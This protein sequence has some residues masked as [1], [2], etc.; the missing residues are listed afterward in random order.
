MVV[1]TSSLRYD[2]G[3]LLKGIGTRASKSRLT[4]YEARTLLEC[5]STCAKGRQEGV[6]CFL[7]KEGGKK[8]YMTLL[9]SVLSDGW[10]GKRVE[11]MR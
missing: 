1:A 10:I 9:D 4:T 5:L 6:S 11:N 3:K 2:D 7:V 8:A